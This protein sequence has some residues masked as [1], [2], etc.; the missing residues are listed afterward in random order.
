LLIVAH[1]GSTAV[2]VV[3]TPGH[4]QGR[5]RVGHD[6]LGDPTEGAAGSKV[7]A[8]FRPLATL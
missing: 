3:G 4:F 5:D 8:A 1:R 6:N 7:L 2:F